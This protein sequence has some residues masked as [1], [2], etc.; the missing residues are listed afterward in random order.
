MGLGELYIAVLG[1]PGVAESRAAP[2]DAMLEDPLGGSVTDVTRTHTLVDRGFAG[3][4]HSYEQMVEQCSGPAALDALPTLK[5]VVTA[6]DNEASKPG[7]GRSFAGASP[8][9]YARWLARSCRITAAQR[10]EERLLFISAWNDWA[11]GAHLEPDRRFGYAYLHA[12]A[13]VLRYHYRDRRTEQ[14]LEDNNAAFSKTSDVAIV[15]HCHYEDLVAPIFEQYLSW[16]RGAD[17]FVTVRWD[18]SAEAV[19]EMRRRFPNIYFLRHENRGRDIRPFLFALRHIQERGYRFACKV[20]TKKTPYAGEG[21]GDLWRRQLLAPLLGAPESV[22]RAVGMFG[23]DEKLGLLAP[24]GSLMELSVLRNHID[25]RFWLDRLL[26]RLERPD[27]I[28]SYDIAFPAGSMYWF[29]V[30]ALAG[31]DR[32]VLPEDE[33]EYE[34]GQRDGTL[35]H[36][37]ERLVALYVRQKG[38]Q[39]T[40]LAPL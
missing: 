24:Q 15:F 2:P 20:H 22:A 13:N 17:L 18:V 19:E 38:Y 28:G 40:E 5:H 4:I 16:V 7:E 21:S 34:M 14:L 36:A 3:S 27:L 30:D 25:N 1:S 37:V 33:F 26:R 6:W 32:L 31:I 12:T 9:L 23:D 35:A 29:R 8:G 11:D 10:P 39:I